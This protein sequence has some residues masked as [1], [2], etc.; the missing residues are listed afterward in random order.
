LLIRG[1]LYCS[2]KS[3]QDSSIKRSAIIR[4]VDYSLVRDHMELLLTGADTD[5]VDA[6]LQLLHVHGIAE[7][8]SIITFNNQSIFVVKGSYFE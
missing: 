6:E 3:N 7:K 4:K 8:L 2:S 1:E 5:Q